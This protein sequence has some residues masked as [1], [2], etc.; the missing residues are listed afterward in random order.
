MFALA[1]IPALALITAFKALFE[2]PGTRRVP[3]LVADLGC[4]SVLAVF[5]HPDDEILVASTLA[6]AV[7]RGCEVR[8]VT[9]TRGE[10]GVPKGFSGD[11]A[12]LVFARESEL[13]RFGAALGIQEEHLWEFPDGRLAD[14]SLEVLQDSVVAAIRRYRPDLVLTLDPVAGFTGHPDHR[15]I[16]EAATLAAL[17]ASNTMSGVPRWVARIVFPRRAAWLVPRGDLRRQLRAQPRADIAAAGN[18]RAKLLG[19]RIHETQQ[20]YFPP[21]WARSLLYRFYDREHFSVIVLGPH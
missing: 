21:V 1:L 9:A 8:T 19:M 12:E 2:E 5:A 14:V 6:D 15:R 7:K 3:S 4:R 10:K 20:R 16:G 13:R 11:S 18:T 17:H